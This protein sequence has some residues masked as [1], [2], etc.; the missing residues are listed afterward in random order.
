M[1]EHKFSNQLSIYVPRISIVRSCKILFCWQTA[2]MSSK[3][4]ELVC[5]PTSKE[6]ALLIHN[7]TS[8]RSYQMFCILAILIEISWYFI[9]SQC[10][11]ILSIFSYGYLPSVYLLWWLDFCSYLLPI[12]KLK[13]FFFIVEFQKFFAYFVYRFFIRYMSESIFS[14]SLACL[15]IHLTVPVTKQKFFLKNSN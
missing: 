7:L 6:W 14:Q 4:V 13:L 5:I 10:Q 9:V 11:V 15:Y 3:V 1:C 2:R 12:F 8:S